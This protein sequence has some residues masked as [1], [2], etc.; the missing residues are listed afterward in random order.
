MVKSAYA[1]QYN[2]LTARHWWW[3]SRRDLILQLV[4]QRLKNRSTGEILDVGCAGGQMLQE[5]V[6]LGRV[7]GV[8]PDMNLAEEAAK[9]EEFHL[10]PESIENAPLE[11][12]RYDLALAL[13]VIEHI[14]N[15]LGAL[16]KIHGSL[17]PGGQLIL[18]VPA[19]ASL[20]SE[21]DVA[22]KHFRRYEKKQLMGVLREA[23]FQV[24]LCRFFFFWTVFP[25]LLRRWL[26]RADPADSKKAEQYEVKIPPSSINA[27]L[28]A[29]SSLEHHVAVGLPFPCGTSLLAIAVKKGD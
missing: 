8:E 9:H 11:T 17:K 21:H 29:Y 28:T 5:L 10:I 3:I 23:G 22:N 7:T 13:D 16:R 6:A 15:D 26:F 24:E 14:E 25:F 12:G 19:L 2:E 20:W 27:I 4:R 1:K 18:T